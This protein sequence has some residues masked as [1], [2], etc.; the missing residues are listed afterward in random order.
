MEGA[1]ISRMASVIFQWVPIGL[2]AIELHAA[3]WAATAHS[4]ISLESEIPYGNDDTVISRSNECRLLYFAEA[5]G[6]SQL[7]ICPWRAFGATRLCDTEIEVRQHAKCAG[8]HL[9][10]ISWSWD[11][12]D[13]SSLEDLGFAVDEEYKDISVATIESG[14]LDIEDDRFLKD[15]VLSENA[16]RS[17]FGWLRNA[18]W[19]KNEK[20]IYSH[21]WFDFDESDEEMEDTKSDGGPYKMQIHNKRQM[22]R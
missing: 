11:L 6:H 13:G 4:F 19:P 9:Q 14:S 22:D 17:V 8:Q 18:G 7:P 12:H 20:D 10:Y 1:A 16:T 21:S 2:T 15:E 5:E 3:A